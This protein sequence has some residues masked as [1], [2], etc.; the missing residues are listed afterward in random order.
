MY[1]IRKAK[2]EELI[3]LAHLFDRYRIFY[4]KASDVKGAIHFLEERLKNE[5]AVIFVAEM[6][7]RLVGFVQ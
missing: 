3:E 7:G 1:T 5:D 4:E 6:A 2:K